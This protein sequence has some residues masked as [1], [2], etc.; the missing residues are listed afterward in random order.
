MLKK[1]FF[2]ENLSFQSFLF[3]VAFWVPKFKNQIFYSRSVNCGRI[4]RP[5]CVQ[6]VEIPGQRD[7]SV[8]FGDANFLDEE[9]LE[10]WNIHFGNTWVEIK[11]SWA[12]IIEMS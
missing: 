8:S 1:Y 2:K 6:M 7:S 11:F 12:A 4:A 3:L 10:S 5:M 9:R